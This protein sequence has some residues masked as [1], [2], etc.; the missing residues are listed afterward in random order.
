MIGLDTNVLVRFFVA[1]DPAQGERAARFIESR[2]T[3]DDPGF[4]D[5]IALCEMVWVLS[6]G[7]GFGRAE[8]ARVVDALLASRDIVLED[9]QA[10]RGALRVFERGVADFADALIGLVNRARGCEA[11]ATFDRKAARL[12]G[13]VAVP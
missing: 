8:I 4:V 1:D 9:H 12:D 3:I 2:C 10:V 7:Y 6:S 13:F 11:T 5:R